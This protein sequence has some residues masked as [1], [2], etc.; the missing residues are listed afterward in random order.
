MGFKIINTRDL[1]VP[2]CESLQVIDAID[3]Q[4]PGL[5]FSVGNFAGSSEL[6]VEKVE[7]I[8]GASTPCTDGGIQWGN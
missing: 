6:D 7:V 5:N 1:I 4:A 8:A 2:D 3:N